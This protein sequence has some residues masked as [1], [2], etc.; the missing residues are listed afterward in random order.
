MAAAPPGAPPR[1]SDGGKP[2]LFPDT[3]PEKA[4]RRSR[5]RPSPLPATPPYV[6]LHAASAFSFLDGASLPEDLVAR[7]AEL[8]LPGLALLD[9][10][11]VHGLP[12]LHQAARRAGLRALAGSE[13]VLAGEP[14]TTPPGPFSPRLPL[15]VANAAGYRNLCR[16]LTVAARGRKKG[17][18]AA[19]W[20]Q[21]AA[22]AGGLWALTGGSEGP[23]SRALATGG[24]DAARALL[25]RLV[26]TFPGRV[27]V[28]LQRHGRREEEHRNRALVDLARRLRLPLVATNGVRYARA[29]EKPL[30]DLLT[31]LRHHTSLDAA[32]R[33]LAAH[34]E[35]HLKSAT[36]MARRF[37][38]LPA[39]LAGTAELAARLDFTL[40]D[41][42]YRFPE[43]PVPPGES[44]SSWLRRVTWEGA[45]SRFRPLTT[46]AQAQLERELALIEKLDLAGYFL[47]VWD[48]VTFC[49]REGILC[50]GRGSAANSAVCYALAITAVDPVKMGL[51][52][53]RFLSEE[54]GEWP[55]IDL[56]LPS[57][58]P[59]ERVI[60]HVYARYGPHGAAM[61]ANVITYRDRS[62]AREV[63]R[64]LGFAPEQGERLARRLGSFRRDLARGEPRE[65]AAE[66]TAA[67]LDPAAT[68]VRHFAALWQQIQ[69]LPRHL[70]QHSG[71]MVIAAGRLDEIVPLEPAAMPGRVV[72]QWDKD[73]CA[74]LGILKVDLLGLGMLNALAEAIPLVREHEKVHLDLAHLPPDDAE[75]FA[76]LRAADTVG[77][78]QVESRA[79]MASLPRHAPRRFYDL[80]VQ[81]AIIRPGPIVGGMVHPFF[82]RRLGRAP[83]EYPHPSLAP[84]LARTL[85][86]PLFQEQLLR[87]A[88]VAAGFTGGE[89]EELR[90][91]MGHKRSVAR[92][93]AIEARLRA[94]MAARGIG[95]EA[96]EQIV[97]AITSFALYGFPESHAA[98]FALIAYASAY[99]KRHH[100]VAFLVALLNSWPLGFYHPATLVQ[101]ARRHGVR[102]LPIDV[103]ASGWRCRWE[104]L[105][106]GGGACR[107]GLRFLA[108]LRR[109][110]GEAIARARRE[111]PF[112][113]LDDLRRRARLRADELDTLATAGALASLGLTRRGA[114]WQAALAV[115]PAP[116]LF[117][118]ETAG[119]AAAAA[120]SPLPEMSPRERTAAD[121]A[122][123][124]L[125][126]GRHPL[127]HLRPG[128]AARGI[129]PAAALARLPHG[130][131]VRT[132]GA[133]IVRQRPGTAKGVLFLALEDETGI[134]QA[135]VQPRLFRAVRERLTGTRGLVVEGIVERRDGAVSLRAERLWPL[136][137][138]PPVPSHDFR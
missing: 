72:I 93:R 104:A 66:L 88:M 91:A 15:L 116:P 130:E 119:E 135:I 45:R 133:V 98:S 105:P 87:I 56:D 24:L 55:D 8:E 60:Q 10:N 51:L 1:P 86:V 18:A 127:A 14:G 95:A 38:D 97:Q 22:H 3:R 121:F 101:D 25:E 50:Q 115:R 134:A 74:D 128:L 137:G 81:V 71:G 79:Q 54:R 126:T 52:F 89:A 46:R 12:R 23:L 96:R 113:S 73:D 138:L 78:F 68:R 67:G 35:R 63:A 31:A 77:V 20:E 49:R 5:A 114:L 103:H 28:E 53:E 92:M 61:T 64:A 57:G 17:E 21:L 129:V 39:A 47:I 58:A 26:A 37:H 75:V 80:V 136:P 36:E 85:G 83:V 43:Y 102:V 41:L 117:T 123:A 11:G 7:A 82:E 107:L 125:T 120:P 111:G 44:A 2:S 76:M 34:R 108:G 6:E 109:E 99:L 32:G 94:G 69:N 122:T 100:P 19:D 59:R 16:L 48:L 42:G 110:A 4:Q 40:T 84:I 124:G 13:V 118:A 29:E 9:R 33:L 112:R 90:R 131:R 30:H 70:G 65:L 132:A 27:A 106:E 62:A